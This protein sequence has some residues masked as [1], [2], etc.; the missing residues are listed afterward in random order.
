MEK[1]EKAARLEQLQKGLDIEY[2]A[3]MH[4][5]IE[6]KILLEENET[7]SF[8]LI[9]N[10]YC[11]KPMMN[12]VQ[13]HPKYDTK[14]IDNPVRLMEEIKILTHDT[15]RAQY[16][17]ASISEH[18]AHWLNNKQHED[19]GLTDYVKQSKYYRDIVKS[20]IGTKILHVC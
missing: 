13:D 20:Q 19:R 17:I 4:M 8:S 11:T 6:R 9:L 18:L 16:P 7:K 15:V 14:I 12:R 10:N 3:A 5:F 1:E 2:E